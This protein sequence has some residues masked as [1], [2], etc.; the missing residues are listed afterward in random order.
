MAKAPA[1]PF[2]KGLQVVELPPAEE[3]EKLSVAR[4]REVLRYLR[5]HPLR[6]SKLVVRC[7]E[8]IVAQRLSLGGEQERCLVLEQVA[9]ASLDCNHLDLAE[10]CL[11]ELEERFGRSSRRVMRLR[12]MVLEA[13]GRLDEARKVYEAIRKRCETDNFAA[14][15]IAAVLKAQGKVK[16]AIAFLEQHLGTAQT[17]DEVYKELLNLHIASC[18]G[19]QLPQ[20]DRALSVCEELILQDPHNH[21]WL[22]IYGELLYTVAMEVSGSAQKEKLTLSRK[23]FSQSLVANDARNNTRAVWGLW[24]T[25]KK[26]ESCTAEMNPSERDENRQVHRWASERLRS[27]YAQ[28]TSFADAAALLVGADDD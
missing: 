1:V 24:Q 2:G 27:S 16:D 3:V 20:Y 23:Y 5:Q 13:R 4:I 19:K 10:W 11:Q 17:S 18:H 15:R 22:C 26:L 8:R 9:V 7:G 28:P 6:C 21:V 25:C 14:C 12:G